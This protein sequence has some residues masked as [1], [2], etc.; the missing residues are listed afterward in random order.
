VK[1]LRNS[2]CTSLIKIPD[3]LSDVFMSHTSWDDGNCM[4]RTYKFYQFGEDFVQ[5]QSSY[6]G[7]IYSADDYYV[8]PRQ[9]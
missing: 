5:E 9:D 2:H 7:S 8:L 1:F 6:P 3:D 4:L